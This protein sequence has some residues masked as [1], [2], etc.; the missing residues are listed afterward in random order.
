MEVEEEMKMIVEEEIDGEHI[1]YCIIRYTGEWTTSEEV[2]LDS[3]FRKSLTTQTRPQYRRPGRRNF[4]LCRPS[5]YL[6]IY[7]VGPRLLM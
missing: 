7:L 6:I 3:F 5:S 4:S 1:S 2:Y